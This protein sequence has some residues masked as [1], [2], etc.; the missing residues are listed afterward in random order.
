MLRR[1]SRKENKK[2]T[3]IH[4]VH[5]ELKKA[6]DKMVNILRKYYPTGSSVEFHIMD[7]QIN[8]S[9][10]QVIGH[11]PDGHIRV[12]HDQA[13]KNSRYSIRHVHYENIW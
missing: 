10:G 3:E 13:K 11:D 6:Q 2:M 4:M 12:R 1:L 5:L 7:N 9:T 8:P